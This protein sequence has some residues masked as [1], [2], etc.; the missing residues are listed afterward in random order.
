MKKS[1]NS[2]S[3]RSPLVSKFRKVVHLNGALQ[4]ESGENLLNVKVAYESYGKLNPKKNNAIL[5]CHAIS[6]DSH[7][8]K[9]SQEKPDGEEDLVGWWDSV[10]GAGK[11]LD[12]NKYFVICSNILGSCRGTTGPHSINPKTK[13]AFGKDF[14]RITVDDMVQAQER[15]LTHLGIDSLLCVIGGSLG[16]FQA[17]T[18]AV[19]FPKKVRGCIVLASSA[20][21][22]SQALAF[23][24]VGRNAILQDPNYQDGQ[25]YNSDKKPDVGL[26]IARM[27]GH[28]TYLSR[29]SMQEK[30]DAD[31][32]L[33][34]DIATNFEKKFSVGS[35]LA[36]Q[37]IKFV[38]RFDANSYI[39]LSLAMDSFNLGETKQKL[40]EQLAKS[41]CKW[42]LLSYT[43]DWLFP[44]KQSLEIV[45]SL[46]ALNKTVSYCNIPSIYGH[47]S[48]LLDSEANKHGSLIT[49]FLTKLD[50]ETVTAK[51]NTPHQKTNT[52][53][54]QRMDFKLITELVP[55]ESRV[56]ELGCQDAGLL[57]LFSKDSLG[58]ELDYSQVQSAL[59][60]GVEIIH[61]DLNFG[62]TSFNDKQ[63]DLAILS[64]TL[65]SITNVELLLNEMLRVAEKS[66]VSFPNFAFKPLR[67]MLFYKGRAPK[68]QGWYNYQWYNTPNSRF[69]S[70]LDFQE[71]CKQKNIKICKSIFL[72]SESKKKIIKEP[73]LNADSALF[74]ITKY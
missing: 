59:S 67:E 70:I 2:D 34:R 52:F 15:L 50:G 63:F 69:P 4:L 47:D 23:D 62:L 27:L 32:F 73:N 14:P 28:I 39:T 8:A 31:R 60:K 19:K 45:E 21:L 22:N 61:H 9:H 5:V 25:Y 72:D 30:F 46:L 41:Q 55:K 49:A 17:L 7:M 12:T 56:L 74:L 54:K 10:V 33:P 35:Y 53:L 38:A 42:L 64:Q 37:G 40:K 13:I 36:H 16:G 58:I 24:I 6:G 18:W 71:F 20:Y 43:S 3:I 29:E 11:Y 65:Q 57:Q 66:I 26:A 1:E 48:F 51:K 68:A 44:A